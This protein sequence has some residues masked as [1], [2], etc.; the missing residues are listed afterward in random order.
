MVE[1]LRRRELILPSGSPS[2]VECPYITDGLIFW[3]DGL[4]QGGESGYWIDRIG[5]KRFTLHGCTQSGTGVG[6]S[7]GG[8]A[9]YS[10]AISNNWQNETIEIAISSM[11]MKNKCWVCPANATT[12]GIGLVSSTSADQF[13]INMDGASYKKWNGVSN[14]ARLSANGSYCVINGAQKT[15]NA[16]SDTWSKNQTT[17]TYLGCRY[18]TSA[19]RYCGGTMYNIR[20]YNRILSVAEMQANQAIDVQRFY[21]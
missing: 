2:P 10:G 12:I 1:L 16:T 3:L 14:F 5:G 21:S 8:Y 4:N 6:F 20:I 19:S 15:K 18:T 7:N 11:A 13:S 9:T 17:T